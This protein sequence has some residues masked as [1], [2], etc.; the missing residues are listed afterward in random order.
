EAA[1]P[2][3]ASPL[4]SHKP[5]FANALVQNIGGGNTMVFNRAARDALVQVSVDHEIVAH[6]WLAY[7]LISGMGGEV[8]YDAD[9]AL[10]YRQH[11]GNLVGKNN[12]W[13]DR[14]TRVALLMRGRFR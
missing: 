8:Y 14:A 7:L 2:I 6:D 9:P 10:L 1:N 13:G 3:G 5:S 4:F 12:S 11:G